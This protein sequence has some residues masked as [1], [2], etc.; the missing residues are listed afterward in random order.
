MML[1]SIISKTLQIL[2]ISTESMWVLCTSYKH[3]P[4][5]G[6]LHLIISMNFEYPSN[7]PGVWFTTLIDLSCSCESSASLPIRSPSLNLG[8]KKMKYILLAA[9]YAKFVLC[10]FLSNISR[11]EMGIQCLELHSVFITRHSLSLTE[12]FS[13]SFTFL[14]SSATNGW[15]RQKDNLHPLMGAEIIEVKIWTSN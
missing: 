4:E 5:A 15:W 9:I 6:R 2:I 12:I 8:T 3:K 10:Y 13:S 7:T 11:T 1:I 14:P